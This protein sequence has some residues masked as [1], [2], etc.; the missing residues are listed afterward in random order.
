MNPKRRAK[1]TGLFL[2]GIFAMTACQKKAD[3]GSEEKTIYCKLYK[4]GY[5]DEWLRELGKQF[6]KTFAKEGYRFRLLDPSV[7]NQGDAMVQ[8][9]YQGYNRN[10]V[11]LYFSGTILPYKAVAD[12][13]GCVVDDITEGVYGA[14]P[15]RFDG[16]EEETTIQDKLTDGFDPFWYKYQGKC[17]NFVYEKAVGG[18]LVN[19]KKLEKFASYGAI[20]PKTTNEL[21]RDY[22]IIMEHNID[23]IKPM[24]FLGR[25]P[26]YSQH[27]QYAAVAQYGGIDYWN[28]LISYRSPDYS[29][30]NRQYRFED[31]YELFHDKSLYEMYKAMYAFYDPKT[32]A[33]G[34]VQATISQA[35]SYIT[36]EKGGSV[37]LFDGDWAYNE[38]RNNF[39]GKVN[40]LA[41]INVPVISALGTKL[42][43]KNTIH[44]YNEEKC[45]SILRRCIDLSDE[46]KDEKEIAETVN[47]DSSL[48]ASITEEEALAVSKARGIY[49]NRGSTTGMCY[50]VKDSPHKDICYKFL[51]M[52]ASDDWAGKYKEIAHCVSPFDRTGYSNATNPF[53]QGNN[54]ITTH[55]NRTGIWFYPKSL[56][57]LTGPFGL[58]PDEMSTL[59]L[60]F[61]QQNKSAYNDDNVLQDESIY[62]TAAKEWFEKE[63]NAMKSSWSSYMGDYTAADVVESD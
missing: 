10:K 15:I 51:R 52:F 28:Q 61:F 3:N 49:V 39:Q 30:T 60:T 62:E 41:F 23:S 18:L 58:I 14:K 21:Y 47:G 55:V 16:S 19:T 4:G 32:I 12:D 36:K 50:I 7:D 43:G 37:F 26:G 44:G 2:I 42:W 53:D 34:S 17:Y 63:Y 1:A 9:M 33:P 8:E 31:G 57:Q 54:A 27:L 59:A 45:E 22:K 13:Y 35:H 11:D 40:D 48:N 25:Q 56:R 29:D 46:G 20:V 24:S 38:I 6:E 5:G